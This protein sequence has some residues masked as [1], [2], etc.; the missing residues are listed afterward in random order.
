MNVARP[1]SPYDSA[2]SLAQAP[3][4]GAAL[5][6]ISRGL[7]SFS[8]LFNA[9]SASFIQFID[10]SRL[11]IL[12]AESDDSEFSQVVLYAGALLDVTARE[13]GTRIRQSVTEK[14]MR[15]TPGI[16]SRSLILL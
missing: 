2:S 10:I 14:G 13:R 3:Q 16:Y 4:L 9:S 11:N 8:A 6:S 15:L 5:K 7:P 12:L 1:A